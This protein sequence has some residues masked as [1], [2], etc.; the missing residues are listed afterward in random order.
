MILSLPPLLTLKPKRRGLHANALANI[1]S[2][3]AVRKRTH[4][5]ITFGARWTIVP[6]GP[7]F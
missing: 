4:R 3:A 6:G 7:K 1:K 2:N 5:K